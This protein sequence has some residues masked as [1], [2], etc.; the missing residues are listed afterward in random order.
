MEDLRLYLGE[1][2]A[3]AERLDRLTGQV[4]DQLR[5]LDVDDVARLAADEVP[6]DGARAIDVETV[7]ALLVMLG[8]SASAL[9]EVVGVIRGWLGRGDG[10]R[11]TVRLELGGDVL[12]L[13]EAS[14]ADQ[15]RL[16]DHFLSEHRVSRHGT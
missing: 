14:E 1:D 4:R 5:Q 12:E 13:S 3:D 15:K 2:G 7:G 9:N 6:P 8:N 10:T 16:I 11:R